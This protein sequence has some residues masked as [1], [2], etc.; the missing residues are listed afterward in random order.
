MEEK[1]NN[2]FISVAY[3]LYAIEEGKE[4]FIEE[5]TTEMPYTFM[6]GFGMV[7]PAFEEALA[8]KQKDEKFE[9]TLDKEQAYGDHNDDAVIELGRDVFCIDGKFDEK[10]IFPGASVPLQNEEGQRFQGMV[11]SVDDAQVTI[12][13]NYPLAGKSLKFTGHVIENREATNAEI[14]SFVKQMSGGC[15]CG[16][17]G[18][19]NSGEDGCGSD[20]GGCGGCK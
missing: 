13:L 18:G 12:D 6:T 3:K 9:I 16:C 19:C 15:G 7:L 2:M 1:T 11:L 4:E 17:G 14:E 10:R 5:A 20:C 8:G